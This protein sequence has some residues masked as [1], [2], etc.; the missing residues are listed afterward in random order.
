MVKIYLPMQ[1]TQEMWVVSWVKKIP[2]RRTWQRTPVF[3]PG[4]SHGQKS[5]AGYS[6][7][8][9]KES[10]TTEHTHT[11][12]NKHKYYPFPCKY[13][14]KLKPLYSIFGVDRVNGGWDT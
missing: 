4:K 8:G 3:L 9:F 13:S 11:I 12:R 7:W 10:D 5:L 2:W 14:G 1:E 6:P